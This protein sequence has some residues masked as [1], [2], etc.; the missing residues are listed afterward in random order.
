MSSIIYLNLKKLQ[1]INF[2]WFQ[3]FKP[4]VSNNFS[5][6]SKLLSNNFWKIKSSMLLEKSTFHWK[7]LWSRDSPPWKLYLRTLYGEKIFFS[8]FWSSW[9]FYIWRFLDVASSRDSRITWCEFVG[10]G[11][12]KKST[13]NSNRT[14]LESLAPCLPKRFR[15]S[16]INLKALQIPNQSACFLKAIINVG[17]KFLKSYKKL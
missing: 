12:P 14:V 1:K 7:S 3:F 11:A 2:Q 15:G 9:L 5:F 10:V 17:Q 8:R 13:T 4:I 6:L 16:H